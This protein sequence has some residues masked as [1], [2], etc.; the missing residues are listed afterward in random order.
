MSPYYT[1][2]NSKTQYKR[3]RIASARPEYG[4]AKDVQRQFGIKE[5]LCYHLLRKRA[6]KGVL[7]PGTG[8]SGGKR[9]FDFAS[10]RKFI[11]SQEGE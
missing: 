11:A 9:L 2:L 4:D 3:P 10:I 5:T 7:I 6:I 1:R 8:R